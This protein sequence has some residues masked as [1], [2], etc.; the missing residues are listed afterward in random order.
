MPLDPDVLHATVAIIGDA[1][2]RGG[3]KVRGPIGSGFLVQ[4]PSETYP[5]RS[6]GYMVTAGHV[7][8]DEPY[9]EV[10][11]LQRDGTPFPDEPVSNWKIPHGD[12]IDIA[13]APWDPPAGRQEEEYTALLF[14]G[15][16][17]ESAASLQYGGRIYYVGILEPVKEVMVRSGT[18]GAIGVHLRTKQGWEYAAVLV[19]VRS[20]EGYSGAP[21][22]FERTFPVLERR[23]YDDLPPQFPK[24]MPLGN[25]VDIHQF[26]G[27]FTAHFDDPLL[28]E[29]DDGAPRLELASRAGV[30]VVL[31]VDY[32]RAVL[33]SE[34]MVKDR[35]DRDAKRGPSTDPVITEVRTGRKAAATGNEEFDSFTDLTR[36]L[37]SVPKA[38]LDEK[39]AEQD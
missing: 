35:K 11:A 13:V 32:I 14:V 1:R 3:A 26:V 28:L 25:T 30:G 36:K 16:F 37:L 10:R 31:P 12:K 18:V 17:A 19:D 7:V 34:G 22:Y 9:V 38:E 24:F 39:R 21:V 15:Q 27:M 8:R 33:L 6:W 2:D 5:E 23:Q 20:Y 29:D 4:V